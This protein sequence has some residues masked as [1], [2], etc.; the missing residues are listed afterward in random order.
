MTDLFRHFIMMAVIF[1]LGAC[2][3]HPLATAYPRDESHALALNTHTAMGRA[4]HRLA[5]RHPHQSGFA[6]LPNEEDAF[7]MRIAMIDAAQSSV[8][9]QYYSIN[10]DK[11][12]KLL[13]ESLIKAAD[14]GVRVRVLVDDLNLDGA[15]RTLLVLN[16]HPKVEIRVFNPFATQD[17][18]IFSRLGEMTTELNHLMRRM[19]NKAFIADNAVAIIG[20]RNLGDEY[21]GMADAF[22]FRDLDVFTVGPLAGDISRS[23]DRYWNSERAYPI[24][25]L[26]PPS[27]KK[28]ELH[29]LRAD[30]ETFWDEEKR[31]GE[32]RRLIPLPAQIASGNVALIWAKAELAADAPEKIDRPEEKSGSAPGRRIVSLST[33]ANSELLLV[34]PYF[35]PREAGMEWI[36]DL[37]KRGVAVRILTNSLA[38]TDVVSVHAHYRGYREALLAQGVELHELKPVG[39]LRASG[40]TRPVTL[41]SKVYVIDRRDIVIGSFNMDPRSQQL[42][43]ELAATI[44]SGRMA[45]A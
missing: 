28:E 45:A 42:N 12:G 44:Q 18:S 23:F 3:A 33:R 26:N 6:L 40:K 24:S 13:L 16:G 31:M 9:L 11:T 14:R 34:S 38:S 39:R 43:T 36:A 25:V 35:V 2:A 7:L 20:G 8:D 37:R 21:F 27:L 5:D 4:V 17:Q 22:T 32:L 29:N 41:H 10:K 30:L 19:H 1:F 15:D